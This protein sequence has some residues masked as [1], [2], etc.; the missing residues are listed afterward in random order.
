MINMRLFRLHKKSSS[1]SL[2]NIFWSFLIL[3]VLLNNYTFGQKKVLFD[4]TKAETAANADWVIDADLFN[5][6]YYN[7]GAVSTGGS[8]AN[9]QRYPTPASP[10]AETDWTGGL[11]SFGFGVYGLGYT[12]ETLPWNA[13]ITYGDGTNAQDL[14]NYDVFVMCEPNIMLTASEKTAIL[15]FVNAGGG[16][17]MLADHGG[18]GV[19][20]FPADRNNDGNS[21]VDVF[22]DLMT[23][24]IFGMY[25]EPLSYESETTTNIIVDASDPLLHNASGGGDIG[26]HKVNGSAVM[27]LNAAGNATVKGIIYK[28]GATLGGTSNCYVAYCTYGAGRVVGM[29]DSSPAE[30]V[31]SDPGDVTYE[32]WTFPTG[33]NA[34]DNGNLILNATIWLAG[35]GPKLTVSPLS[36]T[37]YTYV[38]GAGP[39]TSQS[40][41]LS[42]TNL[43]GTQVTVTGPT[44]Y[45]VSTDNTTFSASVVVSYTAPTLSSTTIYVRLKSGLTA[46]TYNGENVTCADNGTASSVTVA[47]SGSVT[48]GGGGGPANIVI[49]EVVDASAFAASFIEIHNAGGTAQDIT[50]WKLYE[51]GGLIATVGSI[52]LQPCDYMVFIRGTLADL[53]ALYG[54]YPGAYSQEGV[55]II[56]GGDYFELKDAGSVSIDM[57]GTIT[58]SLTA[59]NTAY[60]RVDANSTGATIAADWSVL[61]LRDNATPGADNLLSLTNEAC[62]G[63]S[64]PTITTSAAPSGFGNQCINSYYGEKTY[65]VSGTNLT[66]DIIVTPPVGFE[67][68]TTSGSGFVSNPSTLTL[69]Q[70]GGT[71]STTTIYV[72]MYATAVQAYSGN[73]THT[74]TGATQQDIAV[75]GA[76]VD[77][78]PSVSTPTSASIATTTVT[79]G[80]TITD[81]GCSGI[82][83]EGIYYSTT[84][85]FADGTGTKV[86]VTAGAP[87]PAGIFT[88]P[89]SSLTPNTLYY[90]KGFATNT[91][92]ASYTTQGSFTTIHNAPTV[93]SGSGATSSSI[94]ANWSAPTGGGSATYTYT[95][96][97]DNDPAFGSVDF[98]QS[99]IA[100]GTLTVTATGLASSTTYY[101][102]VKAVNA[103]GSSAW[104][105][106]SVG[107]ATLAP[108]PTLTSSVSTL[109]GFTYVEGSGPSSNQT[110]TISGTAL[111]GSGNITVTGTTN[112]EV[113]TDGTTFAA[114]VTYAYTSGVITGQPKTVY[115]RLKSGLTNASSPY[116]GENVAISGGSA[117]TINVA[118]SGTVTLPSSTCATSLIISEYYEGASNDKYLEIYNGTGASVNLTGYKISIYTNGSTTA[119]DIALSGTVA[120]DAL[121]II[122]HSSSNPTILGFANQTSASLGFN[123]DDA[124]ALRTTGNAIV[125]V[126]G[127][128]GTDPGTQWSG[129]GYSTLDNT[130]VRNADILGGD[131]NGS[132]AFDPSVQ[133]TGYALGT[134][135]YSGSHSMS[136][137][138]V[139]TTSVSTLTGFTYAETAG[140]STNQ[141]YTISGS[142]LTGSGNIT[143]TGSTNYE[144]STDGTT[145]AASVTY[146]YASGVITGQPKTVYVRLKAGLTNASSP[147]NGEIISNAGGGA[148]TV[149][150][151]CSGTVT[152]APSPTLTSSVSTLTGFTYI[153]GAGPSANQTFT[154]SGTALS[155]SGNIT[156]TG[157]TNY[158]VSTDGTTYGASV[159]YPYA[160]G[161]ITGQPKTVYVRLKVGL[162]AGNYNSENVAISGGSATTINVTCSGTVTSGSAPEPIT[163]CVT[164]WVAADWTYNAVSGTTTIFAIQS[165]SYII[166]PAMNFDLYTGETL[167]F[168]ART[169]GG[170]NAAKNTITVSISVNNGSTWT[171][172]GTRTPTNTTLTAMAAFDLSSYSGTQVKIKFE[173]LGADGAI[174]VQMDDICIEGSIICLT[175]TTQASSIVFSSV[176]AYG[177][178]IDWTNGDG[179]KR[180]VFVKENAGAITNPSNS[181]TYTA[182]SDWSVKGTQLGTSGYYCVYNGTGTTVTLTNLA[183]NTPYYVQ[184]F[185]YG[186]STGNEM[187]YTVTATSNP[188][189][190]TT[191][192]ANPTLV[193]TPASLTGLD[194]NLGSGPSVAQSF[195]ISGT[196]LTAGP[197]T[198]TAPAN[199]VVCST[200][201]GTY[202]SNYTITYTAPTLASTTVY[203]KLAAGLGVNS[204]SGNVTCAGGSATTQNV[205]VSGAVVPASGIAI[206]E[207]GPLNI[208]D[209]CDVAGTYAT[210]QVFHV[211]GTN[212]T[213]NM[214]IGFSFTS[215]K[216]QISL[217]NITYYTA[218]GAATITVVPVANSV[219]ET[220][221]IRSQGGFG[222]ATGSTA[223]CTCAST[224]ATSKSINAVYSIF[225]GPSVGVPNGTGTT[226]V[227]ECS[228]ATFTVTNLGHNYQWQ[229]CEAFPSTTWID[230]AGATTTTLTVPTVSASMDG[231]KYR[232]VA[233]LTTAPYCSVYSSSNEMIVT[234]SS[235][236]ASACGT[237]AFNGGTTNPCGWTF[238]NIN[239]TDATN[240]GA[241]T[242]A[243]LFDATGDKVITAT[244]ISPTIMSFWI[245]GLGTMTGSSLLVEGFN[246]YSWQ[247]IEN[248]TTLPTVSTTKTYTSGANSI[249]LYSKFRFTFT[250][251]G[252]SANLAFDDVSVTCGTTSTAWLIDEKFDAVTSIATITNT[253][254]TGFTAS[255]TGG[256]TI[257]TS[258]AA[259]T[260]NRGMN[261]IRFGGAIGTPDPSGAT[262]TI[263][264]PAFAN[265]DLVSFFWWGTSGSLLVEKGIAAKSINATSWSA[266]TTISGNQTYG[267]LHFIDLTADI[268]QLRFTYTVN[269]GYAYF[270]DLRVRDASKGGNYRDDLKILQTL[271][272][273]CGGNEGTNEAVIFKTGALPVKVENL[274][275]SFPNV[276]SG[277]NEYSM[278]ASQKFTTN[279]TYISNLNDLVHLSDAT[280]T[281]SV[282][283]PS[284]T[285]PA[286]SY[287]IIL[288]GRSPS[289]IYDMLPS[290]PTIFYTIFC[291][292]TN[293]QGRY[294]NSLA[295]GDRA[296]TALIDKSTGSYDS[297]YYD[298]GINTYTAGAIAQYDETTG[299]RAYID[300]NCELAL[301]VELISFNAYCDDYNV[302]LSWKTATEVNN[303]YFSIE[304]SDDLKK[305]SIVATVKGSGNSNSLKT[306]MYNDI[307][308]RMST[309][310]YRLKQTDYNGKFKYFD[311]IPV[312]CNF[313]NIQELTLY[314]NPSKTYLNCEFYSPIECDVEIDIISTFGQIL[315]NNKYSIHKGINNIVFDLRSLSDGVYH[316]KIYSEKGDLNK[317]QKFIKQ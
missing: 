48:S 127:V 165:T 27:T 40:F 57:C 302:Y 49:T 281:P 294:G 34:G 200:V 151:T 215:S 139:I 102:R 172:L 289:F 292:N 235:S 13:S 119:S 164:D 32:G 91:A 29:G 291:D 194:Y 208:E 266:L 150:V 269:S 284:G 275:V 2:F 33:A 250:K 249:D 304:K 130:L 20:T 35:T 245:K 221:Y 14:S 217:D 107:Y 18:D 104:S 300:G 295:V 282:E 232:I 186:C 185:E 71:V 218:A 219:N 109:T 192:V 147:Y 199:F 17:Y 201:G 152:A 190:Q 158:E 280:C 55:G 255:Q 22:N 117:T 47:N 120:D 263:T 283:P 162:S 313:D 81:E 225:T 63:G 11:S 310:Y 187:Y 222:T 122:A 134:T 301:P 77:N 180:A 115:V 83:E 135:S 257:A 196:D 69:T 258:T 287:G 191:L 267:R 268:I 290:C 224:G 46:G 70:S 43:D 230:I 50:G 80:A 248:I 276:G 157:S 167:N 314:P 193:V 252:G 253:N 272:Q 61:A 68:S 286:N 45:E 227:A 74:S 97:V 270:D 155:G 124:V 176:T 154:I 125:D 15:A 82:S 28:T 133:W 86:S 100:S 197:I 41:S 262:V 137:G 254:T 240:F 153:Q 228:N 156:V 140:P 123:G 96:E 211:T 209:I 56:N 129:G 42:G 112:Y 204:Y 108:T 178:K 231:Y 88:I 305:W 306:Y 19:S 114:S 184:V 169:N 271:I 277:G 64:T 220:V 179:L 293:T 89:V 163:P 261:S 144:V 52:T 141:T 234:P 106:N 233:T 168:K 16:L 173:T 279:P 31:T 72:R 87:Y 53:T 203:V 118:C 251:G 311:P 160:S 307:N 12:V 181:T 246:G 288:T 98:T 128:I 90:Y 244:V 189:N 259:A 126:I 7:T 62:V 58:T 299:A 212:L 30:D 298:N 210:P 76:G 78:A 37:G 213:A 39:S 183:S 101:F 274:S 95:V 166:S 51:N 5:L 23:G 303:D 146:A 111:V 84:N 316:F 260:Y 175:P 238:T 264:T 1:R 10:T 24:N 297:Q 205:A 223:T 236:P 36:L 149:N 174:G 214:T 207:A 79:L 206:T 171:T 136:C 198:I 93:G 103:G 105:S 110:F 239:A 265:A 237:E 256:G 73:I 9:A 278:E 99:S 285:I 177:M 138:P 170:V 182:S 116:N 94:A 315:I 241:A 21:S 3:I 161:V 85:G 143:V 226:T 229:Q 4:A 242:P 25:F 145:F 67:I 132:D 38:V 247:T 308:E 216:V 59:A 159:T 66:A 65:T 26:G 273:S 243:L 148:T 44:N 309:V 142:N 195:T 317:N 75:S 131:T 8:E 92:G 202:V 54:A 113:S 188:N 6:R 312:N 296:Y 121:H 60:E